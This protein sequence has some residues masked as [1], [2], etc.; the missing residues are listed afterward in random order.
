MRVF[1]AT[2]AIAISTGFLCDTG[3]ADQSESGDT[4]PQGDKLTTRQYNNRLPPVLPGEEV[5]TET[6]QKMRVWSS[7]GPVPVNPRPTPQVLNGNGNNGFGGVIV[8]GR[9]G[10]GG[11]PQVPERPGDDL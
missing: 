1:I 7:S 2:L 6:G 4:A 5:V 3:W 9:G 10:G 11:R 8:D